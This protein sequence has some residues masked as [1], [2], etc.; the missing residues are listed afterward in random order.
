MFSSK[1]KKGESRFEVLGIRNLQWIKEL[2]GA[3][4]LG[5]CPDNVIFSTSEK[6]FWEIITDDTAIP[7]GEF[8]MEFHLPELFLSCYIIARRILV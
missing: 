6:Y 2:P 3:Y 1:E 4:L 8:N 5:C 7:W